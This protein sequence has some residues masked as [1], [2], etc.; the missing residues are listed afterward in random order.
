M[1]ADILRP[2]LPLDAAGRGV[3]RRV[4]Q[5][6]N[7]ASSVGGSRELQAVNAIIGGNLRTTETLIFFG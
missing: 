6:S 4:D 2:R 7:P 5:H 1:L 3:D